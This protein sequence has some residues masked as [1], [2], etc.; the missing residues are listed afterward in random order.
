MLSIF[1][2]LGTLV[3]GDSS[4]F[5]Y[6]K[7]GR[8]LEVKEMPRFEGRFCYFTLPNGEKS[9]LPAKN[10]DFDKTEKY[11]QELKDR[12]KATAEALEKPAENDVVPDEKQEEPKVI[13]LKGKWQLEKYQDK[14]QNASSGKMEKLEEENSSDLGPAIVQTWNSSDDIYLAEESIQR[15]R[16]GYRIKCT[17]KVNQ[18]AGVTNARLKVVISLDNG[19]FINMEQLA[20][21]STIPYEGEAVIFFICETDYLIKGTTYTVSADLP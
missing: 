6:M 13:K 3:L 21:P 1:L 8:L 4:Y 12:A 20:N 2:L 9:M 7:D 19:T 15:T 16:S 18:P 17:L 5:L 10:I 14:G 11:N